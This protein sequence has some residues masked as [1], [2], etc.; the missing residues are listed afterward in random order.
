MKKAFTL[1]ELLVVIA[2][3]AILAA[4]LFPVFAQAKE[5]AKA[6]TNLNNLKQ[7]GL[8]HIQY[9]NDYDD[10]FA[11]AVRYESVAGQTAVYNGTTGSTLAGAIPWQEA[12][13]SYAKN[14]DVY[15]SPHESSATG[16]GAAKAW[17]Q[18]QYYGVIP[19]LSATSFGGLVK[20]PLISG[21]AAYIDGPFGVAVSL[22]A[23]TTTGTG[24]AAG[25]SVA[26]QTQSGIDHLADV[27]M[28]CDGG[29]YDLGFLSNGFA[30][31]SGSAPAS[32][33]A[34][35]YAP[36]PWTGAVYAGPWARKGAS[37][38]YKGGKSAVY[39]SGQLGAATV[40]TCDGSA[41]RYDLKG[42]V[43]ETKTLTGGAVV[44]YRLYTGSV[45]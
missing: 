2:I 35:T 26:S 4:I 14:R 23:A 12:V 7:I 17:T 32:F 28:V 20:S 31:G 25:G 36:T 29:A 41:K 6:T 44:A 16:T 39:E 1:I 42:K 43:Y 10:A 15:T 24:V 27:V 21:G 34:S 38:A 11:L 45:Q 8:A 13:Y 37:G 18:A 40:A 33:T 5:A 22:D 3:I 9:T 30:N 19:R